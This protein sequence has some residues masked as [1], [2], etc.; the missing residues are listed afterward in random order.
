MY[1]VQ[2]TKTRIGMN[3]KIEINVPIFTWIYVV[4]Q[5]LAMFL[6][7][8]YGAK[9]FG[10]Q[11]I[12]LIVFYILCLIIDKNCYFFGASKL[13]MEDNIV[14]LKLPFRKS[15]IIPLVNINNIEKTGSKHRSGEYYRIKYEGG[16]FNTYY[17][18]YKNRSSVVGFIEELQRRVDEAK[19]EVS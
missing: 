11:I 16:I 4:L 5:Q 2:T 13:I 3:G 12:F 10:K 18:S 19:R 1:K 7:F 15:V 8:V 17:L 9:M 14:K 6:F